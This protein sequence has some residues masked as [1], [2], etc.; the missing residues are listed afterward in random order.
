MQYT[1]NCRARIIAEI[2]GY[3]YKNMLDGNP[4]QRLEAEYDLADSEWFREL[5][6]AVKVTEYDHVIHLLNT[7]QD[8]LEVM[9][10]NHEYSFASREMFKQRQELIKD[11]LQIIEKCTTG[12]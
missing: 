6:K 2:S 8:N 5:C 12:K 9:K 7:I 3:L 10:K 1:S 11:I 4:T